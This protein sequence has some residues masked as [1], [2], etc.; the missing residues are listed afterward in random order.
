MLVALVSRFALRHRAELR[1]DLW[2]GALI[3]V[4]LS[5]AIVAIADHSGRTLLTL[6]ISLP[7]QSETAAIPETGLRVARDTT[8]DADRDKTPLAIEA[9]E[10]ALATGN[11]SVED[12]GAIAVRPARFDL[13]QRG[14]MLVTAAALGWLIG[15]VIG[16]IRIILGCYRL[17]VIVRDS[18]PLDSGLHR[19]TLAQIRNALGVASLPP[20]VCSSRVREPLAIGL[21]G[22]VVVLPEGLPESIS[23]DALRHILVHECAHI[24]RRDLLVGLLQRLAAT[25]YWP[26][27]LVHYLNGQLAR[28]REEVCDNHVLQTGDRFTYA[29]T[30]LTLTQMC[31]SAGDAAR[32]WVCSGFDGRWPTVLPG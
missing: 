2:L 28:S 21:V 13:V 7:G 20:I 16:L 26:H 4:L 3:W 8:T 15:V 24:V 6:P 32:A 22:P 19:E 14:S 12:R 9:A 29:R 30:L 27:P 11:S 18:R 1:H 5:P 17:G 31:R 10:E 23:S 25:L